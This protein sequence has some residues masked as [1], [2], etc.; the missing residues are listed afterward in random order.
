[1]PTDGDW[2]YDKNGKKITENF[3]KLL[4]QHGITHTRSCPASTT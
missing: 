4:T 2:L 1:M 3:G